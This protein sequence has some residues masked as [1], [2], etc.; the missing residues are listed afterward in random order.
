MPFISGTSTF[1]VGGAGSYTVSPIPAGA[2]VNW[3]VTGG[4]T[5]ISPQGA[6]TAVVL[7]NWYGRATIQATITYCGASYQT[8]QFSVFVT[9]KPNLDV[10]YVYN[11]GSSTPL[12]ITYIIGDEQFTVSASTSSAGSIV[13]FALFAGP[14]PATPG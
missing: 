9:N 11:N 1:C 8:P 5:L 10:N 4:I 6:L 13:K 14:V 3:Q 2:T 12:N 7:G